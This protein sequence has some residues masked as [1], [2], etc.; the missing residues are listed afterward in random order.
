MNISRFAT[1]VALAVPALLGL[2]G[3]MHAQN[4]VPFKGTL[5]ATHTVT[6]VTPPFVVDVYLTGAGNAT[7]LGA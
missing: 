2:V 6:P 1:A 7:Q 5:Q 3:P 4:L